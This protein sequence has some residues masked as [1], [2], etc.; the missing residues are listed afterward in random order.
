M[1]VGEG[2]RK[3]GNR[4]YKV[5]KA[6]QRL[7]QGIKKTQTESAGYGSAFLRGIKKGYRG[8]KKPS[9]KAQTHLQKHWKKYANV[10]GHA[11]GSAVAYGYGIKHGTSITNFNPYQRESNRRLQKSAKRLEKLQTDALKKLEKQRRY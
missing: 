6:S 1:S 3:M 8:P 4:F 9:G 10:G 11:V 5:Y 7:G 2:K